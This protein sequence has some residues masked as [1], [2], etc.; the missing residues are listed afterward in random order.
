MFFPFS[1]FFA[2]LTSPSNK[3]QNTKVKSKNISVSNL[4]FLNKIIDIFE[5]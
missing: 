1:S 3:F 4:L 2:Q 5:K